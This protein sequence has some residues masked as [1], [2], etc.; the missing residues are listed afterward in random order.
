M[1]KEFNIKPLVTSI[2]D[3]TDI[4]VPVSTGFP[5]P[6][7][8]S[9]TDETIGSSTFKLEN[10]SIPEA[11]TDE[12]DVILQESSDEGDLLPDS[13]ELIDEK[14]SEV[15]KSLQDILK[16]PSPITLIKKSQ[17]LKENFANFINHLVTKISEWFSS[18]NDDMIYRIYELSSYDKVWISSLRS[19]L[20]E[21]KYL[22]LNL[23]FRSCIAFNKWQE[24]LAKALL[25]LRV[26]EN[27]NEISAYLTSCNSKLTY[28]DISSLY[29]E[30]NINIA[31]S[32]M[33]TEELQLHDIEITLLEKTALYSDST[34]QK[35]FS[36]FNFDIKNVRWQFENVYDLFS[37]IS[38]QYIKESSYKDRQIMA[39]LWY[40]RNADTM[41]KLNIT[42]DSL[43]EEKW[44]FY[45]KVS[46]IIL[47][48][49][50]FERNYFWLYVRTEIMNRYFKEVTRLFYW[51][52]DVCSNRNEWSLIRGNYDFT[53]QK[54]KNSLTDILTFKKLILELNDN[55]IA[56]FLK[57]L[58]YSIVSEKLTVTKKGL[59]KIR[60]LMTLILSENYSEYKKIYNFFEDL[61]TFMDYNMDSTFSEIAFNFKKI[62]IFA[63][64]II[65]AV[66]ALIWLYIYSP[67]WVFVSSFILLASYLKQH[68]F[69]FKAWIEWNLWIRTFAYSILVISS[70]YWITNLD[71]TKID[72]AKLS[73]KIEKIGIYKTDKTALIIW[74]KLNDL[75][76]W[77]A[78]ADIL[79]FKWK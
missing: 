79:Q 50:C 52:K 49:E 66:A 7:P 58:I 45:A 12:N 15:L 46:S 1:W 44:S 40:S 14:A 38:K 43:M 56:P 63:A 55:L 59:L 26:W 17:E 16:N 9:W 4:S 78:I 3:A 54:E 74:D 27:E 62:K 28:K 75:K 29:F 53:K 33:T 77:E 47:E 11:L 24:V 34:K 61:E 67:V 57:P 30:L 5:D 31:T 19:Y 20:E 70:F 2:N 10:I 65:V 68:F 41:K 73:W 23:H 60:Y 51:N 39:F 6:M 35:L 76:I 48:R 32:D 25:M 8:T 37:H 21:A 36:I 64:D 13:I 71:A 72:I 69:K 22:D 18:Q 42:L